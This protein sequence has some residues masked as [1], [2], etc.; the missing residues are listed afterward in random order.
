MI[1]TQK[2]L[3]LPS[4]CTENI[5]QTGLAIQRYTVSSIHPFILLLIFLGK[6]LLYNQWVQVLNFNFLLRLFTGNN[7]WLPVV[8]GTATLFCLWSWGEGIRQLIVIWKTRTGW[9]MATHRSCVQRWTKYVEII[10]SSQNTQN[11]AVLFDDLDSLGASSNCSFVV[12]LRFSISLVL[13]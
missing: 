5:L 13:V 6:F 1:L 10:K 11:K 12:V 7:V 9:K 2:K 4:H 3:H 8:C